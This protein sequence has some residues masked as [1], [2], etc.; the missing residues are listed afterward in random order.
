MDAIPGFIKWGVGFIVA[1]IVCFVLSNTPSA[2]A[3]GAPPVIPIGI[4]L[5]LI[6]VVT[7]TRPIWR[8]MLAER[9]ARR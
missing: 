5:C 2:Q 3:N 9:S 4:I 7:L 8:R 1:G 6:G